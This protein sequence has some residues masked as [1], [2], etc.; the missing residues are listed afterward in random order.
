[1]AD[2][3]EV[4]WTGEWKGVWEEQ[5]RGQRWGTGERKDLMHKKGKGIDGGNLWGNRRL[6][7]G[8]DEKR[9]GVTREGGGGGWWLVS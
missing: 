3:G 7:V 6:L 5:G 4:K 9:V 1:M 8:R 2:T